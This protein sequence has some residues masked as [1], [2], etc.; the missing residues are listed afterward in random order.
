MARVRM[1]WD[2]RQVA[3][4]LAHAVGIALALVAGVGDAAAQQSL[5]RSFHPAN[6]RVLQ[7]YSAE[8]PPVGPSYGSMRFG[9]FQDHT[10]R[11]LREAPDAPETFEML[12]YG[13]R[14]DQAADVLRRLIPTR[15]GDI[16]WSF[17]LLWRRNVFRTLAAAG[18]EDPLPDLIAEARARLDGMSPSDAAEVERRLILLEN[19]GAA[20]RPGR[21]DALLAF[22]ARYP[23]TPAAREAEVDVITSTTSR[24]DEWIQPLEEVA[25]RYPGTTAAAMAL[26]EK[27]FQLS[28][29]LRPGTNPTDRFLEVFAIVRELES[30][31]YP[32]SEAVRRAPWLAIEMSPRNADLAPEDVS[33]LLDAFIAFTRIHF[34]LPEDGQMAGGIDGVVL[35]QIADLF[36]RQERGIDGVEQTLD[37]LERIDSPRARFLRGA[38]YA[39]LLEAEPPATR[40]ALLARAVEVLSALAAGDGLHARRALATLASLRYGEGDLAAARDTFVA[41]LSRHPDTPWAWV[42]AIRVGQCHEL[43]GDLDAA[44][45]AYRAAA[46]DYAAGRVAR[47]LGYSY[48]ARAAEAVGWFEEA[49]ADYERA[50]EGWGALARTA[51]MEGGR[52]SYRSCP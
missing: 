13:E 5:G 24:R 12:V 45:D 27:A 48:A 43:L 3:P 42:A 17:D 26:H 39:Q 29:N 4:R 32:D 11:L 28:R 15:P 21:R 30:G 50:L 38:F 47:Q 40:P 23:D 35:G 14:P 31:R 7:N 19:P 51:R 41:Y 33:R 2:R 37:E 18:R 36:A 8:F 16:A 44:I 46:R 49:A 9:L 52:G 25:S 20:P 34:T 1:R 10:E 22:I 6:E